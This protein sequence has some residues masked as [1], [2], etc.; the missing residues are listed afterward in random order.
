MTMNNV[1]ADRRALLS[2]YQKG[3]FKHVDECWFKSMAFHS[4]LFILHSV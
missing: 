4:V 2:K 3:I 1:I